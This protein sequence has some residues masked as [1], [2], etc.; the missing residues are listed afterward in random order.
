MSSSDEQAKSARPAT[1]ASAVKVAPPPA[2]PFQKEAIVV[3]AVLAAF[4]FCGMY[5]FLREPLE[6]SLFIGLVG[7]AIGAFRFTM[8]A[9]I[10]RR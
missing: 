4:G 3:G 5:F 10:K 6:K 9:M 7:G 8:R 2:S 1:N